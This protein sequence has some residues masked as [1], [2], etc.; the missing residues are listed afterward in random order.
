MFSSVIKP[1]CK[2]KERKEKD[3]I[4]DREPGLTQEKN[5]QPGG[6]HPILDCLLS[7]T[8]TQHVK[9]L[10]DIVSG[11]DTHTYRE[12]DAQYIHPI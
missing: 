5:C 8:P 11:G 2:G 4:W 3:K 9:C 12:R 7:P 6:G 1:V 10:K